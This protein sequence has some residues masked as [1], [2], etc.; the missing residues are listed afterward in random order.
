MG[1]S[2]PVD[3]TGTGARPTHPLY[4]LVD[5]THGKTPHFQPPCRAT[6]PLQAS[7]TDSA[8][9]APAKKRGETGPRGIRRENQTAL[10]GGFQAWRTRSAELTAS[11]SG[12][13]AESVR[14]LERKNT[15]HQPALSARLRPRTP[16]CVRLAPHSFT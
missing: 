13:M 9:Q 11:A 5:Y 14:Q 15:S 2:R 6:R 7:A 16:A 12:Q 10:G 8:R 3:L 4:A 1:K